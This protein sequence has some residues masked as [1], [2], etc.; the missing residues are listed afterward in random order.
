MLGQSFL[1]S[2]GS[3]FECSE[4][5]FKPYSYCAVASVLLFEK[6]RSEHVG[7]VRLGA[8]R[9]CGGCQAPRL[10]EVGEG[11]DISNCPSLEEH[12][13]PMTCDQPGHMTI[14]TADDTASLPGR[15]FP[16]GAQFQNE[17]TLDHPQAS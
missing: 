16:K 8:A 15:A 3:V 14:C 5:N 13:R 2:S 11:E 17:P 4:D 10:L 7:R 12:R 9:Y 1:V 6:V